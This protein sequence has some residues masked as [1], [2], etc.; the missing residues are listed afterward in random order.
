MSDDPGDR[1][2]VFVETTGH[3]GPANLTGVLHHL[4]TAWQ[5]RHSNDVVLCHYADFTADLRG[6]LLRLASALAFDLTSAR[7]EELASEA[8]LDRMRARADDVVPNAQH[9]WKDHR[10]FLRAGGS[11]EWRAR[12]SMDDLARYDEVVA[13]AVSPDLARWAH[14]GRL[15]SG[16]DPARP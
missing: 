12:V 4:D 7:A 2:R 3:T 13:A 9:I 15:R 1:F 16:I 14:E 5:R 6:E 8:T 11:G 10:A